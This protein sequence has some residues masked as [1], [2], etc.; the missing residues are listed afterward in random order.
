MQQ[1]ASLGL[2][3]I[4]EEGGSSSGGAV[5]Q[6]NSSGVG[7]HI[8]DDYFKSRFALQ[9]SGRNPFL[10]L[11]P[12]AE[13]KPKRP[14]VSPS[15]GATVASSSS[16]SA[17]ASAPRK[18]FLA[19]RT[20][21][22]RSMEDIVNEVKATV[23]QPEVAS[24]ASSSSGVDVVLQTSSTPKSFS[25]SGGGGPLSAATSPLGGTIGGG[26]GGLGLTGVDGGP[27]GSSSLDLVELEKMNYD[28]WEQICLVY[29]KQAID[30]LAQSD[31]QLTAFDQ[32]LDDIRRGF[33]S[34][35]NK[36]SETLSIPTREV[37]LAA[38][39]V[40]YDRLSDALWTETNKR[41]KHCEKEIAK[42]IEDTC[43][44][45][46]KVMELLTTAEQVFFNHFRFASEACSFVQQVYEPAAAPVLAEDG[47][48]A[49]C[50]VGF[51]KKRA[52][53]GRFVGGVN[54]AGELPVS[55]PAKF[56]APSD[57]KLALG[58]LMAEL[59]E[60]T[61]QQQSEPSFS[62]DVVL[63]VLRA[64]YEQ[65]ASRAS[66]FGKIAGLSLQTAYSERCHA[67]LGRFSKMYVEMREA[68]LTT[69]RGM[70]SWIGIRVGMENETINKYMKAI[71][72]RAEASKTKTLLSECPVEAA[73]LEEC[74]PVPP[75]P[76]QSVSSRR[77]GS[78][79][80]SQQRNRSSVQSSASSATQ[81]GGASAS[82]VV[83]LASISSAAAG[84][85]SCFPVSVLV[86]CLLPSS[87]NA[88]G[89]SFYDRLTSLYKQ[90]LRY[91]RPDVFPATLLRFPIQKLVEFIRS[92]ARW[93][94]SP[95][96]A[97]LLY[98]RKLRS[99]AFAKI[100]V[101]LNEQGL[102]KVS[103]GQLLEYTAE[104]TEDVFTKL[105]IFDDFGDKQQL[106]K[107]LFGAL[108]GV[109]GM[110]AYY[111]SARV[112]GEFHLRQLSRPQMED[113]GF[114][115]GVEQKCREVLETLESNPKA[116]GIVSQTS[117]AR[118]FSKARQS[119]ALF[120]QLVSLL[121]GDSVVSNFFA[122]VKLMLGIYLDECA[123]A[124]NF[125]S[126]LAE[127]EKEKQA[128]IAEGSHTS[129][130]GEDN[131]GEGGETGEGEN[132]EGGENA[133]NAEPEPPEPPKGVVA[134]RKLHALLTAEK[135]LDKELTRSVQTFVAEF[136][137]SVL[138]EAQQLD[139]EDADVSVPVSVLF[140]PVVIYVPVVKILSHC[141]HKFV[142][143]VPVTW[144]WC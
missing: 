22:G 136:F 99:D 89:S 115:N 87:G 1:S 78:A 23:L 108:S 110:F 135:L 85:A 62:N 118:I 77:S 98:K 109:L 101:A 93:T 58:D 127:K 33:E 45:H 144:D 102:S 14:S 81:G 36:K 80:T 97:P 131:T 63:P 57:K 41:R 60:A 130:D 139:A 71:R 51:T 50:V 24:V 122:Y 91:E 66:E 46:G 61:E 6:G 72:I 4:A 114:A 54:A 52:E 94:P 7:L 120:L 35:V 73:I 30:L 125:E 19:I 121:P 105:D 29:Q 112:D 8:L 88:G 126:Y 10:P 31:G 39:R 59:E 111:P 123:G 2:P 95:V 76:V 18:N 13:T 20:S 27:P 107:I 47:T 103:S 140:N 53:I 75:F 138:P 26:A 86:E 21:G 68:A 84:G 44:W 116:T 38:L 37:T 56:K 143:G 67:S 113:L 137:N 65:H 134:V 119:S 74:A 40:D 32:E 82:S 12:L 11:E 48:M 28:Q 83:G 128:K 90:A 42:I 106:N 104:I 43:W 79:P 55:L 132:A 17:A 5:E 117:S 96:M 100:A 92:S 16:S 142:R 3:A 64:M 34:F 70:E 9:S 133:E 15:A 49:T 129:A 25:T 141:G 69:F 124:P